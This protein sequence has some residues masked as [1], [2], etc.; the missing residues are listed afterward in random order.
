MGRR[1]LMSDLDNLI[2]HRDRHPKRAPRHAFRD[3]LKLARAADGA[4]FVR[5]DLGDRARPEVDAFV[6][7]EM[8]ARLEANRFDPMIVTAIS[9]WRHADRCGLRLHLNGQRRADDLSDLR[10]FVGLTIATLE[11][12]LRPDDDAVL[13]DALLLQ[14]GICAM[15]ASTAGIPQSQ[16]KL[17]LPGPISEL[18]A[19]LWHPDRAERAEWQPAAEH[20]PWCRFGH[21][22]LRDELNHEDGLRL[23][24][25]SPPTHSGPMTEDPMRTL[26]ALAALPPAPT[27]IITD[28]DWGPP[29]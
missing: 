7:G 25:R 11:A 14:D 26:R 1:V 13:E 22:A 2:V 17:S 10:R 8:Q 12:A 9:L 21:L 4:E 27:P 19:S 28:S 15:L 23:S 5:A 24:L 20:A 6:C 3:A 29:F 18:G 16:V